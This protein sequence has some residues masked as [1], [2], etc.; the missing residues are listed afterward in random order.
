MTVIKLLTVIYLMGASAFAFALLVILL[1]VI[2]VDTV[3]KRIDLAVPIVSGFLLMMGSKLGA[4]VV[5]RRAEK[6]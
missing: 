3:G 1:S 2:G 5:L 6:H 4:G